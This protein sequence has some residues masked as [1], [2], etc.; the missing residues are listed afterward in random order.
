MAT[1]K[2]Q[3]YVPRTHLRPLSVDGKGVQINL[4]NIDRK[5]AI[6][7]VP[8]K[9][10]C[11]GDYF[12]GTDMRLDQAIRT[13]EDPYGPIVQQLSAGGPISAGVDI[14]LRRFTYL[15]HLRTDAASRK[16]AEMAFALTELPGADAPELSFREATR[17]AVLMAMQYYAESMG[18]ID[19]LKLSIVRNRT[20]VPFVTSDNPAIMTNR[21]HIQRGPR[22]RRGFG[23]VAAGMVFLLPLSPTLLALF[24]DGDVYHVSNQDGWIDVSRPAD[25]Q[26]L[27]QHQYLNAM[28]NIYF[29]GWADR[30]Q[31]LADIATALPLRPAS[32]HQIIHA[33]LEHEDGAGARY[34]VRPVADIADGERVLVHVISNH[35]T[36]S[37]WPSFLRYRPD[38]SAWSNG[39]E[40]GL[41]RR[42]C[43]AA[44]YAEPDGYR[45]VKI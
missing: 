8:A 12:Y 23:A 7:G 14:L 44:G 28:A 40:A 4:I 2:N 6:A 5:R 15:Q 45:R 26:A 1:N 34:A 43:L 20:A 18:I 33:V 22:D 38:A 19:D 16:A 27:N 25:V 11:S 3:H 9:S 37:S 41:T 39:S 24:R 35:P 29:R 42:G 17:S 10:Q 13:I 32:A 30:E 21:W 31:I 36:P